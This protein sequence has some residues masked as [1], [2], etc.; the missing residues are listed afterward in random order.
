MSE[1]A[2]KKP[3]FFVRSA[4]AI[5]KWFREMRSELKKVSWPTFKQVLNNTG[6]VLSMIIIVAIIIGVFDLVWSRIVTWII[7]L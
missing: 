3:N 6:I 2:V 7:T 4:R 1:Q 5:A